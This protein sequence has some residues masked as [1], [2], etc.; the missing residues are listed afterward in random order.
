MDLAM[1]RMVFN[2]PIVS[3]H[4]RLYTMYMKTGSLIPSPRGMGMRVEG[5]YMA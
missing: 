4:K 3:V 1:A 5:K 2:R